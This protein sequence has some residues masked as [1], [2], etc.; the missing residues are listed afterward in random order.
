MDRIKK[1]SRKLNRVGKVKLL[2]TMAQLV[3]ITETYLTVCWKW[4]VP[5]P[6]RKHRTVQ[7]WE[8]VWL[9]LKETG[10]G[11]FSLI[12]GCEQGGFRHKWRAWSFNIWGAT[13]IT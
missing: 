13:L 11:L 8:Y 1:G 3:T 9:R 4:F 10:Y 7:K 6:C 2:I 12:D 5:Y